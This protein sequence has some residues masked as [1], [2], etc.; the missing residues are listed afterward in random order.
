[1]TVRVSEADFDIAAE[2][3][4]LVEAD[5]DVGAVVTFTGTVRETTARGKLRAM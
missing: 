4:R 1:M 5:R 2:C 3:R